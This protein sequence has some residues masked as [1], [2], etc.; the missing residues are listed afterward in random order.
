[1]DLFD[2]TEIAYKN[3]YNIGYTKGYTDAKCAKTEICSICVCQPVCAIFNATG[4]VAQCE[5][6]HTKES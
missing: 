2:A 5:Y 1:M 6:F 3:G 4:G